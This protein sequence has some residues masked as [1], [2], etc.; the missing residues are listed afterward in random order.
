MLIDLIRLPTNIH[1]PLDRRI[2]LI[3]SHTKNTIHNDRG[4]YIHG[5]LSSQADLT[6]GGKTEG[7]FDNLYKATHI[8][9]D[10]KFI[11]ETVF[12]IMDGIGYCLYSKILSAN[13]A[14]IGIS[15]DSVRRYQTTTTPTSSITDFIG[16]EDGIRYCNGGDITIVPPIFGESSL[17][18]YVDQLS[19]EVYTNPN[20]VSDYLSRYK[21]IHQHAPT[22]SEAFCTGRFFKLPTFELIHTHPLIQIHHHKWRLYEQLQMK[23]IANG[24]TVYTDH[25]MFDELMV[26]IA[27]SLPLNY[28]STSIIDHAVDG[29]DLLWLIRE[30]HDP[31]TH[32]FSNRVSESYNN[33]LTHIFN[34]CVRIYCNSF[35]VDINSFRNEKYNPSTITITKNSYEEVCIIVDDKIN[36][37]HACFYTFLPSLL[38]TT[39]SMGWYRQL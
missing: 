6:I 27:T 33:T 37:H 8:S 22:V 11:F 4:I 35:R 30:Y 12:S 3:T 17:R 26:R 18:D 14:L 31:F 36:N 34:H 5:L 13:S 32:I 38:M 20:F 9:R 7:R 19:N 23:I 28:S 39:L 15:S 16:E 1:T 25:P 21:P 29:I 2:N 10:E 24:C